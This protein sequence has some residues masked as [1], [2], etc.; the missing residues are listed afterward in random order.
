MGNWPTKMNAR[1][2]NRKWA[3]PEVGFRGSV[4]GVTEEIADCGN[5]ATVA[6]WERPDTQ[7]E[8]LSEGQLVNINQGSDCDEKGGQPTGPKPHI[9]GAPGDTLRP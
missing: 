2:S 4:C 1:R 8:R 3:M 9:Q 6:V 5:V 7:P